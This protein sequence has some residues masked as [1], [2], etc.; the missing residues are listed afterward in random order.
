ML[1]EHD[2]T[3]DQAGWFVSLG[4]DSSGGFVIEYEGHRHAIHYFPVQFWSD[5][6]RHAKAALAD[7]G[8]DPDDLGNFIPYESPPTWEPEQ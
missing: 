3:N 7:W 8:L 5:E 2:R 1:N 6:V 4:L